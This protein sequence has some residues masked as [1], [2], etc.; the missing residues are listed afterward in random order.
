MGEKGIIG[1]MG[2]PGSPSSEC[3]AVPC[4]LLRQLTLHFVYLYTCMHM[5]DITSPNLNVMLQCTYTLQHCQLKGKL[6]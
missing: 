3:L 5:K 2:P 6:M 1:D 4:V